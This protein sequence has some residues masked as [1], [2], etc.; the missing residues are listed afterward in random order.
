[1]VL[2]HAA[3]V[4]SY[5]RLLLYCTLQSVRWYTVSLSAT[6]HPVLLGCAAIQC[7]VLGWYGSTGCAVL[8]QR[9]LLC[10]LRY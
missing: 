9:M 3:P 1:M 10:D 6:Q 4:L 8:S 5:L 2:L 7:A